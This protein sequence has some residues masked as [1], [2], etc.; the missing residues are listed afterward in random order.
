MIVKFKNILWTGL[1]LLGISL[2]LIFIDSLLRYI[3]EVY[4]F[5]N[6]SPFSVPFASDAS[7]IRNVVA[8]F[9]Y[10]SFFVF[11]Y[12]L[13]AVILFHFTLKKIG[14]IILWKRLAIGI[15]VCFLFFI[16]YWGIA[17]LFETAILLEGLVVYPLLGIVLSL[18]HN[19]LFSFWQK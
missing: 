12:Y 10:I 14:G 13:S 7:P 17:E 16:P 5:I 4:N 6:V 1:K 9:V 8:I 15:A 19:Q 18:L 3:I 11:W 2:V